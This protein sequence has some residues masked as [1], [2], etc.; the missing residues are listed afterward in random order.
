MDARKRAM[1]K[2]LLTAENENNEK[3]SELHENFQ[4]RNAKLKTEASAKLAKVEEDYAKSLKKTQIT[5][6]QM[7]TKQEEY[8]NIIAKRNY[9]AKYTKPTFLK[10]HEKE[11]PNSFYLQVLGCRGA[12]KSTFLNRIFRATGLRKF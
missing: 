7:Q 8:L 4:A 1:S 11:N 5:A 9:E 6:K 3:I 12:G 2:K 10:N